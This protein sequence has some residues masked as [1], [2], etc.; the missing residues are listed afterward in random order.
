MNVTLSNAAIQLDPWSVNHGASQKGDC[1]FEERET[2]LES[3][4]MGT[5]VGSTS[6]T[7]DAR[8]GIGDVVTYNTTPP[9]PSPHKREDHLTME[10]PIPRGRGRSLDIFQKW[11]KCF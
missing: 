10:N 11:G 6:L 1:D 7:G 3:R 5:L 9:H 2:T 4:T 8:F